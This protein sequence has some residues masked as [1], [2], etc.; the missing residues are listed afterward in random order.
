MR[1][2][3]RMQILWAFYILADRIYQLGNLRTEMPP[4]HPG[5]NLKEMY[6]GPLTIKSRCQTKSLRTCP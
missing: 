4:V 5:E 2:A 6:L 3:Y 1:K